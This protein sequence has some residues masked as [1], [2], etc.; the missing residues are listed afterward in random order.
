MDGEGYLMR[1]A[2][3]GV[4]DGQVVAEKDI[5]DGIVQE[6]LQSLRWTVKR[7]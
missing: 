6:Y 1:W 5:D 3:Y 2:G 7:S 4:E